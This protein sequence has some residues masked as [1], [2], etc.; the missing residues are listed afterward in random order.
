MYWVRVWCDMCVVSIRGYVWCEACVVS[1]GVRVWCDVCSMYWG[2]WCDVSA[3][4]LCGCVPMCVF[5]AVHVC[6]CDE[7]VVCTGV[8]VCMC[9]GATADGVFRQVSWRGDM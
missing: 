8:C 1:T 2:V 3:V 9:V 4:C 6:W 5:V 7:C